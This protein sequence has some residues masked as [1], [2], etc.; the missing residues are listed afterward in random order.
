[1]SLL[2]RWLPGFARHVPPEAQAAARRWRAAPPFDPG[3][4]PDALRWVVADVETSGLDPQRDALIAIGA[5]AVTG[6]TVDLA[7]AFEVVLR[8]SSASE[9]ANIEVHGIGRAEQLSGIEPAA[10]LSGFL[11][12]IGGD[13]L[14]AYHAPFD[15]TVLARAFRSEVGIAFRP[16][17]LDLAKLAPLL[18]PG[19]TS[20]TGGL[21]G[22]LETFAIP[23]GTRHRAIADCVAT[24]QLLL[25]CLA[26]APQAGAPTAGAI[27]ELAEGAHWIRR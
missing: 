18:W 16:R 13:P 22:W 24:A 11:D 25:A 5:I 17:W 8:Q 27:F 9:V 26:R 20:P 14:V 7:D 15:A 10:A 6:G 19:R 23:I 4:A 21:D 3:A 2:G 12:F 1:V